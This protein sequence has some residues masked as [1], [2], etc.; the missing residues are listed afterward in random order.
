MFHHVQICSLGF[1]SQGE[2]ILGFQQGGNQ[3]TFEKQVA[4][5]K[6]KT[7]MLCNNTL[8]QRKIELLNRE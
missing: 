6:C 4:S 8:S 3:L 1:G 2:G 7:K 5:V